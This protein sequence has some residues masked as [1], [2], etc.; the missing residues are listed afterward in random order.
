MV[1]QRANHRNRQHWNI[2]SVINQ[3]EEETKKVHL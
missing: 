1:M 2:K 3:D